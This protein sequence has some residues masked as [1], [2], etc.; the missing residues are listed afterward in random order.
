[1]E[2][3][4]VAGRSCGTCNVCCVVPTI[5]EPALQKLPG[6]RCHNALPS[7]ACA[8]HAARPRTCREFFC[9]WRALK[10]IGEG[11]RPDASG[12][13][14]RLVKEATLVQGLERSAVTFTLLDD[15]SLQAPGLAEAI[16]AAIHA[17]VST[18]LIV[19]GPPGYA[20]SRV[21]LNEALGEAV[22]QRDK[23]ALLRT[24]GELRA[25]AQ[26]TATTRPVILASHAE[27]CAG[28]PAETPTDT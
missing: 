12:V 15:A 4:L 21:R 18:H 5:D 26:A 9:G 14:V 16:A 20:S 3:N 19:P 25:E 8:I 10:W 17:D 27:N 2:T 7:G 13:L 22:R 23:P 11:L 1:M 28:C 6:Y 24:L